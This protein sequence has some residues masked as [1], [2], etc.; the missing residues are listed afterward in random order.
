[1]LD[2]PPQEIVERTGGGVL[3]APDDP[4]KLSVLTLTNRSPSP[5]RC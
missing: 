5:R 1:M 2:G 3:V 4:V